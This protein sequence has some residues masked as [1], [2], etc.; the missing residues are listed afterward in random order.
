M[1]KETVLSCRCREFAPLELSG[2]K[3]CAPPDISAISGGASL[4]D[5]PSPG[6]GLFSKRRP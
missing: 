6:I 3:I 2:G 5:I 4:K 1:K